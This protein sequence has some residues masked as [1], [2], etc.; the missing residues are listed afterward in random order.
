M[1]NYISTDELK[2]KLG[3][4]TVGSD[5]QD[6][7]ITFCVS[8]AESI[9]EHYT[10]TFFYE[11]TITD[12]YVDQYAISENL[13][14]M[15]EDRCLI[16]CPA[17]IL[18]ITA[19]TDD[20]TTLTANSDYYLYKST[21]EIQSS[22]SF[23]SSRRSVK[24]SG[25]FGY[26]TVPDDIKECALQIAQ[27]ISGLAVTTYMDDEGDVQSVIKSNV[28]SWIWSYLKSRRWANV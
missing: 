8:A 16:W 21:G 26:S 24:L 20:D 14:K 27:A 28:P 3:R 23:G 11:K 22:G 18:T 25:T 2:V 10:G 17:K 15:S 5:V 4:T 7:K 19:L 6:T 9:V 12:E 13:F 1:G